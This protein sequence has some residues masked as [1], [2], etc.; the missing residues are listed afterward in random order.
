MRGPLKPQQ[1]QEKTNKKFKETRFG[2]FVHK[3][4]QKVPEALELVGAIAGGNPVDVMKEATDLFRRKAD[5]GNVEAAAMLDE[6]VAR[7]EEFMRDLVT[8][9]ELEIRD[10]ESAR[11]MQII[12]LQQDDRFSK[13]YI[14]LLASFVVIVAS[15]F[16]V[17]LFF[18]DFPEGNRRLIEMFADIYLFAGALMV[19]QFFFGSSKSSQSK[20]QILEKQIS[21]QQSGQD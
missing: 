5:A 8:L 3:A 19:L 10:R 13:R 2:Q 16:G 7:E 18:V 12:A 6:L 21:R 11:Q 15:A 20:D 14:Y 17:M 1:M 9:Y 4:G